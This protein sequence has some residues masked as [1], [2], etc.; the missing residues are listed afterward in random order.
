MN[1]ILLITFLLFNFSYGFKVEQEF[2]IK[3]VKVLSKQSANYKEFYAKI[4]SDRSKVYDINLRF[5]GFVTK[6]YA[7]ED[8][9]Y[10]KKGDKLFDIYSQEIYNLYD[11]LHIAKKSSK[12][13]YNSIKNKFELF[14]IDPKNK[15]KNNSTTIKSDISGYITKHNLNNG[16]FIKKGKSILTITDL[17][18]VWAIVNV[19][20]KDIAFVKEGMSVELS[21]DGIKDTFKAKVSHIY[22]RVNPQDQTVSVKVEVNNKDMKL[23]P[24]MFAKAKIYETSKTILLLPK[25]AI[26]KRDSKQYVFIKSGKEYEPSEVKALRVPDGYNIIEGLQEGDEVV[27]NAL[28]LIDSDAVTNGL[29]SDD[30]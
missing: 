14:N 25:N 4:E 23:F 27:T 22:P 18:S 10:I 11:E 15:A 2:N 20:Q 24:N 3:T 30:W 6:L 1:K 21:V 17:S 12:S 28:F 13:M 29:Y 8:F 16:S 7:N 5:D 19:Y 9:M 26:V